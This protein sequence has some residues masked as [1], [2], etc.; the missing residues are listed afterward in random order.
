MTNKKKLW[1]IFGPV[2]AAFA[3]IGLLFLLPFP[4]SHLSQQAIR[5]S[6]V[7]FAS[8]IIKGEAV[9]KAA[10][11]NKQTNY[12]PF[13]GSSE[14]TRFDSMHPSVL[15]AKYH[16]DYQ[17]FMMG[18][19][20]TE[21]M[22]HYMSMQ[23][24]R[25][26]LNHKKAVFIVSPQWFTKK[27]VNVF[28][29]NF[30]SPLQLVDWLLN[31]QKITPTDQFM[32]KSL[33]N[34]SVVSQSNLYAGLVT[35][36]EN[37]QALSTAEI[38]RLRLEHRI[39]S[40]EDQLFSNY[41]GSN[42][43]QNKVVKNMQSLPDDYNSADLDSVVTKQAEK[44]S[45][46]NHFL[47]KNS[48]YKQRIV[49]Q[50]KRLKGSQVKFNYRESVEYSYMQAVLDQFAQEHTDVLFVIAPVN[51]RWSDYTGLSRE[52][53]YQSVDKIKYQLQS[54]GFNNIADLS[55]RG[56]E[57]YFMQDT[58]HIGWR[59]WLEADQYINPFLSSDYQDVNYQINDRFLSTDWQKF[60]SSKQNVESF[61]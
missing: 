41:V 29:S 17:P 10:F 14:L 21:S 15:A 43:W 6:S 27:G 38:G 20:G 19:A 52:M 60:D 23:E 3:L 1:Q 24:M 40:R 9:K 51:Q 57:K 5:E 46:S 22:I 18:Q 50:E 58:I 25:P 4:L 42:D 54:Q 36:I 45:N 12:V 53:Y 35:K 11:N 48:F 49:P 28:F 2:L 56:G 39:L 13:F 44:S 33:L 37:G 61:S 26:A 55:H 47:I 34:Q 16:R 7:S 32:A 31:I 30:Y 59:G 8:N